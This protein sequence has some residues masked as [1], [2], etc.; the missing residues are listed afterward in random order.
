MTGTERKMVRAV[1]LTARDLA[2]L[3][4]LTRHVLL[5]F[6]QVQRLAFPMRDHS[7]V[8]NRLKRLEDAGYIHRQRIHRVRHPLLMGDA[9]VVF[10][11]TMRGVVELQK[12]NS[13]KALPERMPS[14]HGRQIDHDL[15]VVEVAELLKREFPGAEYVNGSYLPHERAGDPRPD[16]VLRN[17]ATGRKT[18][19]EVELSMKSADRV[20]EILASYRVRGNYEKVIYFVGSMAIGKRI[21]TEVKGYNVTSFENFQDKLFEIR[22]LPVG[23]ELKNP[24]AALVQ[25]VAA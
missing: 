1:L 3:D 15:I 17:P 6:G 4:L 16:G 21:A 5:S 20:R 9:G 11:I 19:L 12:L 25:G 2:L 10:Q 13:G 24:A 8:M 22:L 23:P 18:A 14:I 7:T